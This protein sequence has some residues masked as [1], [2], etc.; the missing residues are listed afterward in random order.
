MIN[1]IEKFIS[2]LLILF[3]KKVWIKFKKKSKEKVPYNQLTY[4]DLISLINVAGLELRLDMKLKNQ[5]K[6]KMIRS[7]KGN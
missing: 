7:Q 6:K 2:S 5:L 1:W 4:G 3:A